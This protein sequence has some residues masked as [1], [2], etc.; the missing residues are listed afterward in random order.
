MESGIYR[1]FGIPNKAF[2]QLIL[3]TL[4]SNEGPPSDI[5]VDFNKIRQSRFTVTAKI[6]KEIWNF[7]GEGGNA[8]G[9][10]INLWR[11]SRATASWR[12]AW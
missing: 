5:W 6:N 1:D 10:R 7:T 3:S 8:Q 11:K 2:S 12:H 4:S 9:E